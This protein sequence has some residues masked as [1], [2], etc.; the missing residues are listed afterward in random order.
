MNHQNFK[1]KINTVFEKCVEV[2]LNHLKKSIM[3]ELLSQYPPKSKYLQN[4]NN[5]ISA[6]KNHLLS[7]ENEI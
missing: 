2:A 6:L 5:L 4:E 7:L 1:E 3:K